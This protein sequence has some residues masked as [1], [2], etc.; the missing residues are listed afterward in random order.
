VGLWKS[1]VRDCGKKV[2]KK[3]YS[4]NQGLYYDRCERWNIECEILTQFL[5]RAYREEIS[6]TNLSFF[7]FLLLNPLEMMRKRNKQGRRKRRERRKR[8]RRKREWTWSKE[9]RSEDYSKDKN[10]FKIKSEEWLCF[11]TE[12]AFYFPPS[13][14]TS[15]ISSCHWTN[16]IFI[17]V[18]SISKLFPT[19][20]M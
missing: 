10:H 13:I 15:N 20:K 3:E 16:S 11:S 5:K 14:W 12:F 18:Q 4:T 7:E 1:F 9:K 19:W 6:S 8:K 17:Y 2:P